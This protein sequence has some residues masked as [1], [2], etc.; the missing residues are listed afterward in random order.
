MCYY[1]G[2]KSRVEELGFLYLLHPKVLR[3][4]SPVGEVLQEKQWQETLRRV[5]ITRK[6]GS[7]REII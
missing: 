3:L 4:L 1:I 2:V 5:F 6:S 7:R